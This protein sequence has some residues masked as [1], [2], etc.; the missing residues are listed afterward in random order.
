M[1]GQLQRCA[2]CGQKNKNK[3]FASGVCERGLRCDDVLRTVSHVLSLGIERA[4]AH[5]ISWVLK[6]L[7]L[8][9]FLIHVGV[10]LFESILQEQMFGRNA[11]GTGCCTEV[12][13]MVI[14]GDFLDYSD[15]DVNFLLV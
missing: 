15:L 6:L 4:T 1:D 2:R 7:L 10:F 8:F 13:T 11:N 5:G 9:S 12:A 14:R 3:T